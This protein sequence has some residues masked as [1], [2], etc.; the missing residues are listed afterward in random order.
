MYSG[1]NK[2]ARKT[3]I[4]A[5][6]IGAMLM[7]RAESEP[8]L[9]VCIDQANP[10][11]AMDARVARA[12]AK[13]QGYAVKVVPFD[14]YGK[15]GDGFPVGRLAKMA[16]SECELIMGFPVDVSD[17]NLPPNV[18]AT[19]AYASTGFVLIRRGSVNKLSLS[20]LPKGS[21]VGIVQ[22]D[23]YAGLLYGAHPNI[24]MHVYPTDSLMLAD[25][26]AKHIAAGLAWQPSIEIYEKRHPKAPSFKFDI[27]PGRHMLWNLVALYVP[28]SQSAA[29]LFAHGLYDLQSKGQLDQL[30]KP[31]QRPA[32]TGAERTS[33]QRRSAHLQYAV[34]WN[35]AA[36]RLIQVADISATPKKA[37]KKKRSG[38][39]PA[40][41]TE[42]QA[43]KGA[44][45]YYK[46]CSMCHGPLL[47]GQSA[48]YSGPALKGPE[49]ADPSYDFHVNEMFN[50]VAK[51]MPPG[52]PGTLTHEEYVQIMA[53]I[54]QQNGYPA[55]SHELVYE[56]AEKSKVPI[57]YYGK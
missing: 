46:N 3:Q 1:C 18:E 42:E 36:G 2:A 7:H 24:V 28:Q 17:P 43:T 10:T 25:L 56:E 22:L 57:R 29:D 54:L 32:A 8:S 39:V 53:F 15:G 13:T 35:N 21:E 9:N 47:D 52:E 31:Y 40:L 19:S 4:A 27:L 44:L 55:G 41:Y 14:G 33:A 51:L 26:E 23:T 50:F 37:P 12:V 11:S 5:I 38:K 6:I 30:I 34:A 49:F 45:A 48:G 20:E 16:Q